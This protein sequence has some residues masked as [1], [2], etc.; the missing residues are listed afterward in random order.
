[1]IRIKCILGSSNLAF[2]LVFQILFSEFPTGMCILLSV[3][4]GTLGAL[5]DKK[6]F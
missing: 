3:K 1:V 4:F 6:A 5:K 2:C